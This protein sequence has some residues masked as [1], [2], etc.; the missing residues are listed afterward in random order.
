MHYCPLFETLIGK[1]AQMCRT[2]A[3][4]LIHTLGK[5]AIAFIFLVFN[6]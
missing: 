3:G 2:T 4:L 5:L 1:R 6:Y